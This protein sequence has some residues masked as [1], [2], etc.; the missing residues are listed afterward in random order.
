M[1]DSLAE[2]GVSFMGFEGGE[3]FIRRDLPEILKLSHSRFFT[4]LVTNGWMLK[5]RIYE[6]KDYIDHLF[7][8]IDGIGET[9]D[10]LR[11]M[12]GSFERA[13]EGIFAASQY[14]PVSLSSTITSENTEE[15]GGIVQFAMDMGVSVSFQIAYDYSTAEKMSPDTSRLKESI[16]NLLELKKEGAP[17][18]ESKE[19]FEAVLN[20][21][22]GGIGWRCRPWLTLNVDPQG[23]VVL[24]C[25]VLN[26]YTGK[27]RVWEIDLRKAWNSVDWGQYES[28]NRCALSC[29][30]EPSL[31]SWGNLGMVKERIIDNIVSYLRE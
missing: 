22:Y 7:V 28:C 21:W 13:K 14:M 20:S 24:P 9:H 31:F 8:S 12:P 23:R 11:G 3:P 30:L 6:V 27:N 15:V 29:Y 16:M 2:L 19:Y 17:I 10:R 18:V 26:E 5:E 25:Y 4:S 1:L